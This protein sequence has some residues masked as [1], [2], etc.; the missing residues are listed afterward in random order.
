MIRSRFWRAPGPRLLNT[1]GCFNEPGHKKL[2]L[3]A[4][5]QGQP[6]AIVYAEYAQD[7]RDG[8]PLLSVGRYFRRLP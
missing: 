7:M 1:D 3:V 4:H 8:V 2:M 6:R 5:R